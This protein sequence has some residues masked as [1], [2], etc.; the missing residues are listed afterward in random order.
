M[1]NIIIQDGTMAEGNIVGTGGSITPAGLNITNAGIGYTP[2]DGNKTF[3]S[4]NLVTITGTGRGAVA[5][6]YVNN[7]VAAA[8]TITNGGTGYSVGDVLGITTIGLSTGGSGTVGRNARFSITGIGMTNELTIDNVQGEFV[9]GTAN[10]L[11]YTN[12]SGIKT[13]LGYVNG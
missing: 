6:V 3:N 2:L 8:A 7:G 4:V 5:N 1:G 11:F 12:S 10:T 9:V 13:E